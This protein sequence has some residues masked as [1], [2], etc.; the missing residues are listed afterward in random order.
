MRKVMNMIPI[1]L[2][3]IILFK[4]LEKLK[5]LKKTQ[6]IKIKMKIKRK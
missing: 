5:Y 6:K 3:K 1:Y 4:M 2:K